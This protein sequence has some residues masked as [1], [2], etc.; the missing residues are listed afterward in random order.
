MSEEKK[1]F[2]ATGHLPL[3]GTVTTYYLASDEKDVRNAIDAVPLDEGGF[4]SYS[5]T[6]LEEFSQDAYVTCPH[7]DKNFLDTHKV[8]EL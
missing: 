8:E 4:A 6:E 1:R 3:K 5:V 2:S 7:C